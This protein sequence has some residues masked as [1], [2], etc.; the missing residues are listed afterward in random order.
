[1][2]KWK[3]VAKIEDDMKEWA[4]TLGYIGTYCIETRGLIDAILRDYSEQ[5]RLRLGIKGTTPNQPN[6]VPD[7]I[8]ADKHK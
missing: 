2:D 3:R 4:K 8:I 1:M 6:G 5:D 7:V